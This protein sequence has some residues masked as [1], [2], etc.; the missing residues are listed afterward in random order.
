MTD[1]AITK[2]YPL[3]AQEGLG[4]AEIE[5]LYSH[6]ADDLPWVR[7]NF[8][9][10]ADG[11]ATHQGLSGGLSD[12]ADKRVFGILRRLCDVVVVGAG[13]VRAE[14]YSAMRVDAAAERSR[15]AH[16]LTPHPAFA[17]VSASLDLDPASPI[18][19]EAP[20][21]PIVLTTELSQPLARE[22]LAEV[23]DVLVCGRER[24]E[25]GVLVRAL[26]DRGL[27]RIHCEGGPHTFGDLIAAREVD[28]LC[29]TVSPRLESGPAT[30]IAAGASPINPVDLHLAHT[31]VAGDTLLLRYV[32]A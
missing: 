2:L 3:P 9:T 6:G 12:A 30:R 25:A 21:R 11:A 5:A 7:V 22:A 27:G 24:V 20:E 17:I 4:D 14:G 18:F 8:V 1:P 26:A 15:T 23:A 10:S 29:L 16:G 28:E 31:L 32:R 19:T 13:T